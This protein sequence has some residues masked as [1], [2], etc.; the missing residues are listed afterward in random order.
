MLTH[1]TSSSLRARRGIPSMLQS[2]REVVQYRE[3]VGNLVARELKARYKGSVLG[4]VW[5][6]LNPLGMMLVFTFVFSVMMPN[7]QLPNYPIFFLCGYLPWQ[8]FNNGVMA[9]MGSIVGN[10]NLVKKVYFPREVLPISAVLAALVNFL[11]AMVVLFAA[12]LVTK[13]RLSPYLWQLPLVVGIQTCFV[14]AMALVLSSLNVFYRDTMMIMEVVLQAW[15]FLTPV[16]YPIEILP[17]SYQVLGISL[18]IH[19]LMYVLNPMASLI[20]AYRD[21]LYWG[22]RTN[23]DFLLR[24]GVTVLIALLIGYVFFLHYRQRLGEEV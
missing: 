20:A 3:L 1:A 14:L 2:S 22:Y 13:T 10:S 5:S 7:A 9:G 4:F 11:L 21:L 6:L 8:F 24:T 15:F 16:L 12:L 18:D 19:R 23:L 17:R